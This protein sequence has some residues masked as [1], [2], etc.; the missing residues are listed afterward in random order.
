MKILPG[1]LLLVI[2]HWANAQ[3][4]P[5]PHA[6]AHNDYHHE[7]PLL[8][9]LEQGFTSVEAD[10]LLID[11]T[12]Y[13]GHDMPE[14]EHQLPSLQSAYLEPLFRI[15]HNH[16]GKVYPDYEGDFYLM[17]DIKTEAEASYAKLKEL[18]KEYENMLSYTEN[19]TY[20]KRAVTIFLSGNR[21][22]ESV[23][24]ETLR[25]VGIDGRPNDLGKGYDSHF[26][27]FISQHFG[28]VARWNGEGEI[29][30]AEYQK[31]KK[32]ISRA[33]SEGKKVRLWASPDQ[34]N[35][36]E[37]LLKAEADLINTDRL[38]DL[39]NYLIEQYSSGQ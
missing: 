4:V 24:K 38:E 3:V 9:A 32:L 16:R 26:M 21:P 19:G 28:Q 10:V 30:Q 37:V 1:L 13:V 33:H 35:A 17:I 27:P 15:S 29:P 18:L 2:S 20:H 11:N 22:I 6:H 12:L 5:L 14:G 39:K 36:W 23:Q 25:Y 34:Q 7:R 8:D 31:L